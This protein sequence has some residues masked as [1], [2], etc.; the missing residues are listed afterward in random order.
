MWR[1][2]TETNNRWLRS[3]VEQSYFADYAETETHSVGRSNP[4][5]SKKKC[6]QH[7]VLKV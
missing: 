3:L 6:G 2:Y 1:S 7:D 4:K 5:A